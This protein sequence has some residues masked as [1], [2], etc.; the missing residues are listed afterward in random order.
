MN[1][2]KT[3]F[4]FFKQDSIIS[5]LND[6]TMKLVEPF[7]YLGSNIS[8]SESDLNIL[9]TNR[10]TIMD[11]LSTI[12]KSLWLKETVNLPSS[13]HIGTTIWLHH[14]DFNEALRKKLNGNY[15]RMLRDVLNKSWKQN[16]WK[17]K[18]YFHLI[19]IS[20]TIQDE[21]D[22]LGTATETTFSIG[23][24]HMDTPVLLDQQ[25]LLLVSF[26]WILDTVVPAKSE[27]R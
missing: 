22:T 17:Q 19:P 4:M 3:K 6:N 27:G 24:L 26:V 11:R 8:S 12:W 5:I 1:S 23:F 15:A 14:L 2:D 25:K 21:Q 16:P 9:I 18:L 7:A 20:Q 10:W 13:S